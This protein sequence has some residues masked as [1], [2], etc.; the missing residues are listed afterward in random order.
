MPWKERHEAICAALTD[1]E[2]DVICLQEFCF[3]TEGFGQLYEKLLPGFLPWMLKRTGS[4]VLLLAFFRSFAPPAE[5]E[6]NN[7]AFLIFPFLTFLSPS[8]LRVSSPQTR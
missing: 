3:G 8:N 7:A 5:E 6:P 2:P 4:K 1:L